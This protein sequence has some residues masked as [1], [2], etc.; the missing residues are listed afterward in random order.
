[1]NPII[2]KQFEDFKKLCDEFLISAACSSLPNGSYLV[3][4]KGVKLPK[5]WDREQADIL[6]VIPPGYP[7]SQPDCFW[8]EPGKF[9]LKN[10][11]TPQNSNDANLI[12]GETT[13]RDTTWFSWHLQSW[14]PN[15]DTL[16]TYFNVI[17]QRF[18]QAK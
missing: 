12:P 5:G 3:S 7:A 14:S 1:M 4:I 16:M 2:A 11:D 6:F 9:R 8:V 18:N 15:K 10:G 17:M 13:V